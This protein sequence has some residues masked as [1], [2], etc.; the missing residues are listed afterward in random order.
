[1]PWTEIKEMR[2]RSINIVTIMIFKSLTVLTFELCQS[3]I[4][5]NYEKLR[6]EFLNFFLWKK[7]GLVRFGALCLIKTERNIL[8][9]L[10]T[11]LVAFTPPQWH[12]TMSWAWNR[13]E[14]FLSRQCKI[15]KLKIQTRAMKSIQFLES[16][17][18]LSYIFDSTWWEFKNFKKVFF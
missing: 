8:S 15:T 2:S 5:S 1:M 7:K 6:Y 9:W 12:L 4:L 10:V 3:F 11:K 16:E 14:I 18:S 17:K 13:V